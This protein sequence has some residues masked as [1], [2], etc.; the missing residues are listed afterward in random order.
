LADGTGA[1]GGARDTGWH[2]E[3]DLVAEAAAAG[4]H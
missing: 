4:A 1:G 3:A 2:G